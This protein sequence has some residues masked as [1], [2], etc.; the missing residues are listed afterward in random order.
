MGC[1]LGLAFLNTGEVHLGSAIPG[2][3]EVIHCIQVSFR[4]NSD[5]HEMLWGIAKVIW[6]PKFVGLIQHWV[7]FQTMI[8]ELASI[9]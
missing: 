9:K 2:S 7:L 8:Q 6:F 3:C 1:G 4:V 5:Q